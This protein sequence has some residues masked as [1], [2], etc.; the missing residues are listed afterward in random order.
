MH[1]GREKQSARTSVKSIKALSQL[2]GKETKPSCGDCRYGTN[3]R[4]T[5]VPKTKL[6][7]YLHYVFNEKPFFEPITKRRTRRVC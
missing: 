6:S 3:H 5:D 4:L 2:S 7:I 1:D